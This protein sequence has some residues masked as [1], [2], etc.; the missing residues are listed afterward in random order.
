MKT[1]KAM[2]R[3]KKPEKKKWCPLDTP[4]PSDSSPSDE[5]GELGSSSSSWLLGKMGQYSPLA[6]RPPEHYGKESLAG[7]ILQ[8][9][10]W[11]SGFVIVRL[12]HAVQFI[13]IMVDIV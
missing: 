5:A 6:C 10:R 7:Q 12:L 13:E 9:S 1:E 4:S 3:E 2:K 8:A 11:F